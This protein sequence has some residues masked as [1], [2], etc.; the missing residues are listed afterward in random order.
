MISGLSTWKGDLF[1]KIFTPC[2]QNHPI[3]PGNGR[4]GRGSCHF[5]LEKH[6]FRANIARKR[7][8]CMHSSKRERIWR[9]SCQG[10][11]VE[12][13]MARMV[14]A[15]NSRCGD[16]RCGKDEK[17]RP[18]V[19]PLF[20]KAIGSESSSSELERGLR[21]SSSRRVPR[22]SSWGERIRGILQEPWCQQRCDRSYGIPKP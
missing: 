20:I 21:L 9:D 22:S 6:A 1:G 17:K 19:R 12:A 3:A 4:I 10:S 11:A 14:A 15:G 8:Y 13:A 18:H 5:D 16:G 2:I 7:A